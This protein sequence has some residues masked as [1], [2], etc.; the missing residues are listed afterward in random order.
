MNFKKSLCVSF[1]F[2]LSGFA[3]N[4]FS[5]ERGRIVQHAVGQQNE[6]QIEN[7]ENKGNSQTSRRPQPTLT[8]EIKIVQ[9][10]Q[11]LVKKI[12]ST[13]ST[14]PSPH[15]YI[16]KPSYNAVFTQRLLNSVRSKIGVPYLYGSTGPNRYD[17]SG[18]VWSV[19][20]E[21]GYSYERSSARTIWQ[22]SQLVEGDDRFKP[23]TL[24]FF[25]NLGHIGIVADANGFYHASSSK[26]VMY[27]R[28]DGYWKNYIVGF[29]RMIID[30]SL[31]SLK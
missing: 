10:Y 7:I 25:K 6:N 17:C 20:L 5:Q 14:T 2:V 4:A 28:F 27:S 16:D 29:R 18:L 3:G 21:A 13:Q 24:I 1:L 30:N 15:S 31:Y 22:N 26:G 9:T 23:G 12:G 19:F 8:N 11:P